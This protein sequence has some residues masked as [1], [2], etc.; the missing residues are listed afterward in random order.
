MEHK[1][2]TILSSYLSISSNILLSSSGN[3]Y[4]VLINMNTSNMEDA[5]DTSWLFVETFVHENH[6][7]DIC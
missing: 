4:D 2:E 5:S 1:V 3:Y 7:S 6:N